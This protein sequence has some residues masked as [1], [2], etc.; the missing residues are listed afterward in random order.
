MALCCSLWQKTVRR[1]SIRS[2]GNSNERAPERQGKWGPTRHRDARETA[3]SHV[4]VN[5]VLWCRGLHDVYFQEG[6]VHVI[7]VDG[8]AD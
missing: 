4:A 8:K 3:P 1:M 2:G 6:E 5:M 7:V